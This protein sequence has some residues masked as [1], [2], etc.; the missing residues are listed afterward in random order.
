MADSDDDRTGALGRRAV[1][2]GLAGTALV[3]GM[4]RAAARHSDESVY[5][6]RD[7]TIE[8][9]DGTE[10]ACT[11]YEP[12]ASGPRP[13]MLMTHGWGGDRSSAMGPEVFATHGYVVLTYDSR[14][15]GESGGEANSDGPAEVKDAKRLITWLGNANGRD[16]RPDVRNGSHSDYG[17]NPR[18][19]MIGP[20]YAGGIQLNTAARDD[21][22][23][24]I[25]P[26][27]PWYDLS[28]SLEPNDV[29]KQNW[30]ALLYAVGV[31]GTR[32]LSSGDGQPSRE[33]LR[34]GLDSNIHEAFVE[35]TVAN[36]FDGNTETW[37]QERS[38]G[39]KM[40]AIAAGDT[41]CLTIEGWP[42][43]L[44]LPNE[45]IWIHE[46]LAARGVDSRLVLYGS[47]H[48]LNL[49]TNPAAAEADAEAALRRGLSFV[50]EHL[51]GGGGVDRIGPTRAEPVEY[52]E[53]QT[54]EPLAARSWTS[55]ETM[56]PPASRQ[57]ELSLADLETQQSGQTV[58]LNSVVATSASQLF[59]QNHDTPGTSANFDYPITSEL[60]VVGAPTISAQVQ[61]L[62]D[63]THLFWKFYHVRDGTATL[64]NN[65]VMPFRVERSTDAPTGAVTLEGELVAFQR[66]LEP[67]DTL[68]LTVATTDLGFNSA[69]R[70]AG[71]V[72]DHANSSV[73]IPVVA[74]G[75][76]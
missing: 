21:R 54:G 61:P 38:P 47:G 36:G 10:L 32:G 37:Y 43:T 18:V 46:D 41:P 58:V 16:G 75:G 60:E 49:L 53:V 34:N 76:D 12:A 33:D 59:P 64:V 19:G 22:L 55:V 3:A 48:T 74:E 15:F 2:R 14:G 66:Y 27:I 30:G 44:F 73:T 20:S 5:E 39:S 45:G 11:V 7:L 1:L 67:G 31:T 25:V 13:S 52:F 57:W 72:I 50:D 8:S 23:D 9:W 70:S 29:V 40:D 24:V 26:V 17:P 68:R 6:T 28:F 63:A 56:P 51:G 42:D 69:R 35:G 4:G 65:Q 71:A 62:G